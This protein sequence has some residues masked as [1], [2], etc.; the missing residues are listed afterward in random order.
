[1]K[2]YV[3][4]LLT[5]DADAYVAV[6]GDFNAFYFEDSLEL[7]EAG[8]VMSNLLRQLPEEERY[9]Y[10]FGGNAQALDNFLVTPGLLGDVLVDVVHINSEQAAGAGRVS[11]HDPVVASFFLPAADPSP[12][13]ADDT[14]AVDEDGTTANLWTQLLSNDTDP[15]AGDVLTI[16]AVDTSATLGSVEFDPETQTLR[17]IAN[18]D[19]FDSI[20]AGETVTDSFTYTVR[21]MAGNLST[22]TV[23]VTVTGVDDGVTLTGTNV[24]DMLIG[25]VDSDVL[26]GYAGNDT[27]V[28]NGGNDVFDGGTGA[29]SMAGGA[30]NDTY[31]V[32]SVGDTVI[33]LGRR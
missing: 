29:D 14:V 22:A 6:L 19:S 12:V 25:T 4:G 7:L 16:S 1:M 24:A 10:S 30:G 9:S 20:P 8:G 26:N 27:L 3:D 15:D 21:D 23:T 2:D 13:A 33:E 32:D 18:A 28:G 11:D 17:Y 31:Y 5:A